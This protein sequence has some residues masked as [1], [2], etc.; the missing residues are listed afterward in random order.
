[1]KAAIL[2]LQAQQSFLLGLLSA[3]RGE[4]GV[5]KRDAQA[6]RVQI[7]SELRE[8]ASAIAVLVEAQRRRPSASP[9]HRQ[10]DRAAA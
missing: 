2:A 6:A 4:P 10:T 9:A 5:S 3:T 7:R 8:V 1:M